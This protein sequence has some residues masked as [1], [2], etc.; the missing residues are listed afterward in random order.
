MVKVSGSTFRHILGAS[1][2]E[3]IIE[4]GNL[5]GKDGPK[6]SILAKSGE[7]TPENALSYLKTMGNYSFDYGNAHF[8]FV[9]ANPRLFDSRAGACC[10][11]DHPPFNFPEYPSIIKDWL[12]R[13]LDG[14]D[15]LWKFVVYHQPAFNSGDLT[16][17]NNQMRRI[18]KLLE[19]HGVNMVFQ[20][21]QHH[22]QRLFPIRSLPGVADVPTTD[23]DPVVQ[24][25]TAFDGSERTVPDGVIYLVEGA[26]GDWEFDNSFGPPRGAR[27]SLDQED[28]ACGTFTYD[29]PGFTFPQGPDSWLD[30]H[31]TTVQM[32]PFMDGAGSGPKI[33]SKLKGKLFSFGQ[34]VVHDNSL[35]LYQISEPLS[36]ESSAT[37]ENPYPYGTD[38]FG[39]T[40]NDPLSNTLVDPATGLIVSGTT[41]GVPALLDRFTVTK[42][43]L[44]SQ[45]SATLSVRR[46]PRRSD[47][48]V[49]EVVLRNGA[50]LPLNGVQ[51]VLTLPKEIDFVRTS[52]GSATVLGQDAIVT[53]GRLAAGEGTTIEIDGYAHVALAKD[54][55]ARLVM[56]SS[57]ALPITAPLVP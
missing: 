36:D 26:G 1:K 2:N 40:N 4:A 51:I 41:D 13:D 38:L 19:D 12:I 16:L 30:T 46:P 37:K 27:V 50:S 28:S 33:T 47:T 52:L 43:D 29:P 23:R 11:Y 8:V 22:Y 49:F 55:A 25:D 54:H 6:T 35:T 18:A 42:P 15:Q 24:I 45:V 20:G 34:V 21:H 14:S 9:D 32:T 3:T 56:R 39:N 44:R 48:Y 10:T 17:R 57:T 31:L 5:A 53:I 7:V